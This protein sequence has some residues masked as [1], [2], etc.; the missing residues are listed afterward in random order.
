RG[1]LAAAREVTARP[2]ERQDRERDVEPDGVQ[3]RG[4]PDALFPGEVA[5]EIA[6]NENH[7]GT[8]PVVV[9]EQ[10]RARRTIL[11]AGAVVRR[12]L[13][14]ERLARA[15]PANVEHRAAT[16]EAAQPGSLRMGGH[17]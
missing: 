16:A 10:A 17:R 14:L 6:V 9:R 11:D 4:R 7:G 1:W 12:D 3:P 8:R 5:A 13:G 15:L 2:V